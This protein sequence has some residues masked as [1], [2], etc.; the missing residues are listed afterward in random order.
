METRQWDKSRLVAPRDRSE[1]ESRSE[2]LI[3]EKK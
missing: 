3:P 1:V 2:A